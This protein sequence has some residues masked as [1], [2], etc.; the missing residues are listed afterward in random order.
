M[1]R[2]FQYT[3]EREYAS[4]GRLLESKLDFFLTVED[5]ITEASRANNR[6]LASA[7][8]KIQIDEERHVKMLRDLLV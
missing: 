4:I 7:L 6:A 3:S 1:Q 5:K 2:S 8:W